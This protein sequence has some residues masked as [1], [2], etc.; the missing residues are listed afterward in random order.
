MTFALNLI[1]FVDFLRGWEA[2][3]NFPLVEINSLLF[4]GWMISAVSG[5][6]AFVF[7]SLRLYH[8]FRAFEN[9]FLFYHI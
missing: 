3:A 6:L 2:K 9:C 7:E 4:S 1:F 8:F 5:V